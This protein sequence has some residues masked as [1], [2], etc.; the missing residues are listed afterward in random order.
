MN[1]NTRTLIVLAVALAVAG[2]ASYAVYVA[3]QRIP[4][5]NVEVAQAHA[6]VAAKALPVGSLVTPEDVKLV[7]WPAAS[8]IPGSFERIEQVTNRGLVQAVSENEPVTESKLAKAGMGA[9]LPPTIPP[10]MRALSIQV[11][12]VVGV[13]GFVVPGT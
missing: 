13:A 9:G 3:V 6:V 12:E 2:I 8:R 7:P 11:N 5:R 1:R 10:G 4:T